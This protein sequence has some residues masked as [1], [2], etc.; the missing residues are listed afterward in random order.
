M[1]FSIK[2]VMIMCVSS[3]IATSIMISDVY[4]NVSKQD[5]ILSWQKPRYTPEMYKCFVFCKTLYSTLSFS[6][7]VIPGKESIN[8]A[9]PQPGSICYI[10]FLAVY[11]QASL[12]TG[13]KLVVTLPNEGTC[14]IYLY[15]HSCIYIY[16][17]I[18]HVH[19]CIYLY[20]DKQIYKYIL[21]YSKKMLAYTSMNCV[22]SRKLYMIT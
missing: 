8:V 13:I 20:I 16:V 3:F 6:A 2:C 14:I 11:N 19:T 4:A 21:L 18:V 1:C 10:T 7:E 9:Q 22:V 17:Y 15:I 12:D 5:I